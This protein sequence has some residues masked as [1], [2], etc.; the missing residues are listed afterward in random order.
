MAGTAPALCVRER[1]P[2][3]GQEQRV[4][5]AEGMPGTARALCVRERC[6]RRGQE[7]RGGGGEGMAGTARALCVRERC[8]PPRPAL[9]AGN[10]IINLK[11]FPDLGG[12][13]R[14][15]LVFYAFR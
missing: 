7:Q 5:G 3:R 14:P 9:Q 15:R 8:P 11:V 2:P 1:C 4:G 12:M 6:P 13:V 10:P